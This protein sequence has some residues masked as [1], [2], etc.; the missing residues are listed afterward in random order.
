MFVWVLLTLSRAVSDEERT[1][2]MQQVVGA[3]FVVNACL[4]GIW[5]VGPQES[6]RQFKGGGSIQSV[7]SSVACEDIIS[8]F[9]NGEVNTL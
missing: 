1:P 8:V 7:S 9:E 4:S 2:T 5:L 3:A 6:Q